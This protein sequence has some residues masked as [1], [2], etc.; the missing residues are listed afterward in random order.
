MELLNFKSLTRLFVIVFFCA[1]SS[2][3][4]FAVTSV[5]VPKQDIH[6]SIDYNHQVKQTA[7][8]WFVGTFNKMK[9]GV[10]LVTKKI[11]RINIFIILSFF[12]ALVCSA[13]ALGLSRKSSINPRL[14]ELLGGSKMDQEAAARKGRRTLWISTALLTFTGGVAALYDRLFNSKLKK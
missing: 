12:M 14:L 13:L 3:A 8:S 5:A 1:F 10:I 2:N 7:Q 4:A 9:R 6:Q 11:Q